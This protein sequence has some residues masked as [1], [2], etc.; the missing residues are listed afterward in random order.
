MTGNGIEELIIHTS[1]CET[2]VEKGSMHRMIVVFSPIKLVNGVEFIRTF[3]SLTINEINE[4]FCYW[5]GLKYIPIEIGLSIWKTNDFHFKIKSP[6]MFFYRNIHRYSWLDYR[7][8]TNWNIFFW[9]RYRM[10]TKVVGH[11]MKIK[12]FNL[13]YS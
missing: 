1:W 7:W 10:A 12:F 5:C 3:T 9:W 11:I 13:Y 6:N 2:V 4:Y 8:K